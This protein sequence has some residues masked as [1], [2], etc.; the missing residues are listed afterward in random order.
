M[1]KTASKKKKVVRHKIRTDY[2]GRVYGQ[3]FLKLVPKAVL[4]LKEFQKK[5]P[6]DAI[7]FTGSSGAA[8]AFPLSYLLK[9]P[10]IHVRKKDKNHYYGGH[11]EGTISSRRYIIVDDFIESGTTVYKIINTIKKVYTHPAEV[12][13]ICLYDSRSHKS[14]FDGIPVIRIGK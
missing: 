3:S 6:F 7:A 12:V 8:L 14:S 13:G 2:L 4:K 9:V 10:L 1:K 11:I 5:N